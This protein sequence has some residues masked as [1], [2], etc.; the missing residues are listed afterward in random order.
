MDLIL[1]YFETHKEKYQGDAR[2]EAMINA[3]WRKMNKYY[4]LTDESPAYVAAIILNPNLKWAYL[5]YYWKPDWVAK[6]KALMKSLWS[7]YKSQDI[8]PSAASQ[9]AI[10]MD[11]SAA[12]P[13]KRSLAAFMQNHSQASI[14][15]DEYTHYCDQDTVLG[16]G[17]TPLNWWLQ[18][19][20]QKKYPNLSKLAIDILTIPA[21]SAEVERLFSRAK[22]TLND[23]RNRLGMDLLRAFECL[24]SWYKI[25]EFDAGNALEEQIYEGQPAGGLFAAVLAEFEAQKD[26]N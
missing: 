4:K 8:T 24:K 26:P 10:P 19:T 21:M 20:Q 13:L 25:N 14:A 2:L 22:L 15:L 1:S 23:Q 5:N 12:N 7:E 9:A 16:E 17:E 11:T 3:G 6:A 18:P